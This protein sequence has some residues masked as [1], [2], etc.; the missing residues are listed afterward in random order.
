MAA[1]IAVFVD[2][3]FVQTSRLHKASLCSAQA[4]I[5]FTADQTYSCGSFVAKPKKCCLAVWDKKFGVAANGSG[6]GVYAG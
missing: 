6:L 4:A 1:A 2:L 5:F 3:F